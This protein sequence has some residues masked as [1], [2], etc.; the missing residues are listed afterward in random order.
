[1]IRTP[2]R[3]VHRPHPSKFGYVVFDRQCQIH[4]AEYYANPQVGKTMSGKGILLN[5][6]YG[7]VVAE[8]T[9]IEFTTGGLNSITQKEFNKKY[10]R[11][12]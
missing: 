11:R 12:I 10:G 9:F 7:R 6:F 3:Y 2:T 4:V 5:L 8:Y 1:M